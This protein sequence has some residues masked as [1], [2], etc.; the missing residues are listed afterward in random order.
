MDWMRIRYFWIVGPTDLLV[1]IDKQ[2]LK[3]L[4]QAVPDLDRL[5]A[6]PARRLREG[7]IT[8]GP[9]KKYVAT[10]LLG[11]GLAIP[12]WMGIL[13]LFASLLDDKK[14]PLLERPDGPF[15]LALLLGAVLGALVGTTLVASWILRS[16]QMVLTS[17]GVE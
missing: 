6:K 7:P 2:F 10:L 14:G 12:I 13:V 11:F 1:W 5:L 15:L 3:S 17:E 16:G 4:E 9:R 8:I